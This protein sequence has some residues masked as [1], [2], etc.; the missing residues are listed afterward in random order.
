MGGADTSDDEFKF[1]G[2]IV[3]FEVSGV[4]VGGS[5]NVVIPLSRTLLQGSVH[6]KYD[7]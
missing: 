2:D 1:T 5:V 7:L 6:R 3:D 4:A